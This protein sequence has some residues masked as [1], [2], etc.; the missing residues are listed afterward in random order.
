ML[1]DMRMRKLEPKTRAGYIRGVRILAR[2]STGSPDTATVEDLRAFS[3]T[4]STA[5]ARRSPS[6]RRS[7]G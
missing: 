4:W 5:A 3:C 6:M 1:D 2:S 7:P